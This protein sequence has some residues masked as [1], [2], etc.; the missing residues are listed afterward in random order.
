LSNICKPLTKCLFPVAGY[1]TRFLPITKTISKVMLPINT[2]PIIAYGVNEAYNSGFDSMNFVTNQQDVQIENYFKPYKELEKLL[3]DKNKKNELNMLESINNISNNCKFSYIKQKKIQG[4]G[5]AI[6]NAKELVG[7]EDFGVILADDLCFNADDSVLKQM[8]EVYEKYPNYC[9]VAVEEIELKNSHKYGIV[10]G[11][12]I[13]DNVFLLDEMVEK[14][15]RQEAP[16]NLAIIGRYILKNE[17]FDVLEHTKI[18]VGGEL[19]ITDALNSLAKKQKVLAYK[20]KG[21]RYDCGSIDGYMKAQNFF[22]NLSKEA[23]ISND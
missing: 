16:S 3:K 18:G 13:E 8:K 10:S 11:K 7:S 23:K 19:Q 2:K 20:F 9:I 6:L 4:L 15:S 21:V 17:I 12:Q 1:G 5:D 22:Y 14:P